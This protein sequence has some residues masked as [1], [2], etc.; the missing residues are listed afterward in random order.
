MKNKNQIKK[1]LAELYE[2]DPELKKQEKK[3]TQTIAKLMENKPNLKID[4]DFVE[5]LKKNLQAEAE[6]SQTNSLNLL[7]EALLSKWLFVPAGVAVLFLALVLSFDLWNQNSSPGLNEYVQNDSEGKIV[8]LESGAF[9]NLTLNRP[10]RAEESPGVSGGG[11]LNKQ[12]PSGE[13]EGRGA[14]GSASADSSQPRIVPNRINYKFVYTGESLGELE[15]KLPVYK[16]I[17]SRALKESFP[18]ITQSFNPGLIDLN[19]FENLK[20]NHFNL[21]ENNEKGYF[22]NF[23]FSNGS[24]SLN[25]NWATW[26]NP[27]LDC[28]SPACYE[29]YRLEPKDVP[30]NEKIISLANEFL[31]SYKID[32]SSYGEPG[33]R[34]HWREAFALS[35]DKENFRVPDE[36]TVVYPLTIQGQTVREISGQPSGLQINVDIRNQKISGLNNLFEPRFQSSEY[37]TVKSSDKIISRAE[38]GGL[39]KPYQHEDPTETVTIKLGTPE[40][41]LVKVWNYN[42]GKST[43][44]FAPA[45][46]FPVRNISKQTYYSPENIVV[47]LVENLIQDNGPAI[48]IPEVR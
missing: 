3:L 9:G 40:K 21:I 10:D 28:Q 19:K 17:S 15:P 43:E 1:I 16:K 42:Q 22:L 33:I 7:K 46:V 30:E 32:T 35:E 24:I 23:N 25:K 8:K 11:Q 6:S 36:I 12:V 18:D 37:N 38:E 5:K 31:N 27:K 47:P 34:D 14:G 2:L 13:V 41:S 20:P 39:R 4:S 45:Y 48:G 44:L 29:S 26:P